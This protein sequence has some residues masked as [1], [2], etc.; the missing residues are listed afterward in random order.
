[1]IAAPSQDQDF[2]SAFR[3]AQA[4]LVA[5]QFEPGIAA[6]QSL[7]DSLPVRTDAAD[8]LRREQEYRLRIARVAALTFEALGQMN[9]PIRTTSEFDVIPTRCT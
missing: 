2:E 8:E 3:A 9:R 1:M 4:L 6:L 5:E 7:L